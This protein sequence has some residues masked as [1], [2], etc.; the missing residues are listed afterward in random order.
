MARPPSQLWMFHFRCPLCGGA[1]GPTPLRDYLSGWRAA[2]R[3][4]IE[5]LLKTTSAALVEICDRPGRWPTKKV[6]RELERFWSATEAFAQKDRTQFQSYLVA[7]DR[8]VFAFTA[9]CVV[10]FTPPGLRRIDNYFTAWRDACSV[11]FGNLLYEV[12]LMLWTVVAAVPRWADAAALRGMSDA[13]LALHA[14]T[15]AL[16]LFICPQCGR[17]TTCLSGGAESPETDGH[18]RW[19]SDMGGGFGFRLSVVEA[20][21]GTVGVEYAGPSDGIAAARS[22]A[23]LLPP[24]VAARWDAIEA[25]A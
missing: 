25:D 12:G 11:Q 4:Q 5:D 10:C 9:T 6:K 3:P 17:P 7:V 24:E 18:C 13:R 23:D 20:E 21:D 2:D 16:G 15:H 19:C 14:A 8:E 22:D 1:P